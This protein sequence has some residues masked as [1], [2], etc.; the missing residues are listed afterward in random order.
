M[1]MSYNYELNDK[2]CIIFDLDGTLIDHFVAITQSIQYVQNILKIPTSTKYE[3]T[4]AVG[5]GIELTLER[6][7][8]K[9]NVTLALPLFEE[10]LEALKKST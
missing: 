9:E 7:I 10:H 5:G 2:N 3:V 1:S 4:T 8:G 6:L